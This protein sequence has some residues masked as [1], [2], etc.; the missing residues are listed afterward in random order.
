MLLRADLHRLYDA[1]QVANRVTI[2]PDDVF[3]VSPALRNERANGRIYFDLEHTLRA[4]RPPS[5]CPPTQPTGRTGTGW[6]G[7]WGYGVSGM[8]VGGHG[9]P[10]PWGIQAHMVTRS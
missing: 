1:G 4:H 2:T 9:G 5:A 8:K 3:R 6:P 10:G 7:M